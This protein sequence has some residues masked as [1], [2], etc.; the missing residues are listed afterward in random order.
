[1]HSSEWAESIVPVVKQ[2]SS[3][4]IC[5]DNKLTANRVITLE[6][7]RIP[8]IEELF[9]SL[10]GDVKFSKLDLKN[11]YLQLELQKNRSS[12]PLLTPTR[13]CFIIIAY[14][15][16]LYRP[17]PFFKEQLKPCCRAYRTHVLILM[18]LLSRARQM[19]KMYKICNWCFRS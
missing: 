16:E 19:I 11:A 2:D 15:L 12:I 3:V 6:S 5:G 18:T 4:R 9:V 1:M 17:L 14:H 10:S 7:Y 13:V 8:R